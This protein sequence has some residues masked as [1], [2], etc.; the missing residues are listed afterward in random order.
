MFSIINLGISVERLTIT[1]N[2]G[3]CWHRICSWHIWWILSLTLLPSFNWRISLVVTFLQLPLISFR[4]GWMGP[5]F[6]TW[7]EDL[8]TFDILKDFLKQLYNNTLTTGTRFRNWATTPNHKNFE[9]F[10][11]HTEPESLAVPYFDCAKR[12]TFCFTKILHCTRLRGV[13]GISSHDLLPILIILHI[14]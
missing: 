7:P 8:I 13:A 4:E 11:T 3:K 6:T 5:K 9:S 12:F 14:L 10:H 1:S 2:T